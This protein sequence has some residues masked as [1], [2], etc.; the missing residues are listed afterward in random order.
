MTI[1]PPTTTPAAEPGYTTTEFW[2]T[3]STSLLAFLVAMNV[4]HIT[5]TQTQT[6]VG[7]TTMAAAQIA[8]AISRAIR[9]SGTPG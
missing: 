9:K 1:V 5:T 7:F 4:V 3:E 8:Y 6:I 2:G